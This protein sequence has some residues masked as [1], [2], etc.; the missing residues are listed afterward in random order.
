MTELWENNKL[1]SVLRHWVDWCVR[2]SFSEL[3]VEGKLPDDGKA[4]IV[5]PNHCNTLMDALVVL[6]SRRAP[7]AFGARADI[8][9]NPTAA[10]ILHFFRTS[11][12]K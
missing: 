8:F 10:K 2:R 5:A 9:K 7:M 1:Y 3:K 4:V 11:R 12:N 6:Q